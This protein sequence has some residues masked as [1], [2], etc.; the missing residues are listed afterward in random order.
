MNS[1]FLFLSVT[2]CQIKL[3]ISVGIYFMM[4][5]MKHL[6]LS[7][8]ISVAAITAMGQK[9]NP[10]FY[11][12]VAKSE[13]RAYVKSSLFN[14][15]E[16]Y[17]SYDLIYQ[18][19]N[20]EIDPSVKYI[21]G[22]VTSYVKSLAEGL[23]ETQFDLHNALQVDSIK[24]MDINL[25]FTHIDNTIGVQL[26]E[27]LPIGEIDTIT[28]FYQGIP[29][30]TGFGSFVQSTHNNVPIIWTLSEPYGAMEWWPCKQSLS[31]KVDSIDVV[32]TCPE[33]YRAASNGILVSEHV[34]DGKRTIHWKHRFPIAT[35]LVAISVTNY[36][37]YSDYVVLGNGDSIEILNYVY[38][39]DLQ[40]AQANT[41]NTIQFMELF[42]EL[43]IEYPFASEKYGHAQFGWGGGMEHQTM[44]FMGSFNFELVAHE[45]AHQWFGD[46]VTLGSWHDIWLNEGFATYLA[47]L[48][49]ENL[50]D[51][52]YWMPWKEQVLE[53]IVSQEGGSVFVQ[54]TTNVSRI[55]SGRLS[56]RKGAYLL[57][58][59]RW[60]LGDETFFEAIRNYLND[61]QIANSFASHEEL[62]KHFEE[63]GGI[64]LEE[65]FND[66]YYGEGYPIYT[67]QFYQKENLEVIIMVNQQTSHNSVGFFEMPL[68]VRVWKQDGAQHMDFRLE[69]SFDGQ[70]FIVQPGF[71]ISR[72]EFDPDLWLVSKTDTILFSPMLGNDDGL[73]IYP[74]PTTGRVKLVLPR[75]DE[76]NEVAIYDDNGSKILVN[77]TLSGS[78]LDLTGLQKGVYLI[79]LKTNKGDYWDK[80]VLQ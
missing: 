80:I 78:N 18:E 76:V 51:A 37:D 4:N 61:P 20:W 68:P 16:T 63:A 58:M 35:Y 73:I 32:V 17:K 60:K 21:S 72:L 56:Y 29:V 47:G 3:L 14:Q 7:I 44:S 28:I 53:R 42:N 10:D 57:H 26:E 49:Y 66:W 19:L 1:P 34:Q 40:E 62:V 25:G 54:D 46:Y 39:E 27:P 70:L 41:P 24:K 30:E 8:F 75:G 64:S 71:E 45:L 15:H 33:L 11:E 79:N 59:L 69:N 5:S 23:N 52:Q 67:L 43:F 65:F 13:S 74:N 36:V 77:N 6:F 12:K 48:A 22:K 38:P 31:D 55:F 9:P 2:L 50:L